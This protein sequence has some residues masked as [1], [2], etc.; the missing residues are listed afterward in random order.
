[1]KRSRY[2]VAEINQSYIVACGHVGT[3]EIY[4]GEI[5]IKYII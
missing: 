1:M 2:I 4:G 3:S 5:M